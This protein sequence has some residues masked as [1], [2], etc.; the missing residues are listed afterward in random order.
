M[1]QPTIM[2][3]DDDDIDVRVLRRALKKQGVTDNVK[4]AHD[5]L[6]ALDLLREGTP[7][8]SLW[9]WILLVDI[10]MPRMNGHEFL[11]RMRAETG[12]RECIV[13]MLTTSDRQQDIELA[14]ANHVAGYI[15]KSE[16]GI[17]FE[18]LVKLLRNYFNCVQFHRRVGE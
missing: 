11:D 15:V 13:Y 14:Y 2:I 1:A 3:I 12:L 10:N 5:G 18:N 9:P 7:R 4:V 6:E 17:N 8:Q 16:A